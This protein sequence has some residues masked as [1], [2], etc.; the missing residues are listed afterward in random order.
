MVLTLVLASFI[1]EIVCREFV[2]LPLQ[3]E[4]RGF[5]F[6]GRL[7]AISQYFWFNYFPDLISRHNEYLDRMVEFFES[8]V[9]ERIPYA[10]YV[11]DFAVLDDRIYV[12]ELNPFGDVS[13]ACLFS[14]KHDNLLLHGILTKKCVL[15]VRMSPMPDIR[16]RALVPVW[17]KYLI[18][19]RE[20]NNKKK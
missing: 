6:E 20:M 7:V 19:K 5:V 2:E 10:S 16:N 9:R 17:D 13:G 14:W 8:Q 18:A 12:I 1:Q 4:F 15:R 3:S 11:V